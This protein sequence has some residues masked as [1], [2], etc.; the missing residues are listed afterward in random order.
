MKGARWYFHG[1]E[2]YRSVAEAA[3]SPHG[4]VAHLDWTP[5]QS[6][7][8]FAEALDAGLAESDALVAAPWFGFGG[9]VDF[10]PARLARAP[11]LKAIARTLTIASAGSTSTRPPVA[12]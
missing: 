6:V 1:G 12:G 2:R 11:S 7:E 5:D 8:S 10:D 3:L 4:Q 9:M